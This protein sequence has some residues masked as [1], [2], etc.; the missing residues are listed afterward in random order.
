ELQP[1]AYLRE[2]TYV[3]QNPEDELLLGPAYATPVVLDKMGLSLSDIDV[4]VFHEAFAGQI[5][6]ILKALNSDTFAKEKLNRE[7]KV[8]EIPMYKFNL[9]D[10][11]L[12][13]CH[14]FGATGTRIF[15]TTANRLHQEDGSF[16]LF[17]VCAAGAQGHAMILQRYES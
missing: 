17:T 6:T 12:S 14:P 1:M 8:G 2:Y 16:A 10:G 5:L 15:T 11:S 4:F 9:W 13:L 7:Q 3:A